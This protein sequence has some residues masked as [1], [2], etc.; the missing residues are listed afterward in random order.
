[1]NGF[2]EKHYEAP[3]KKMLVTVGNEVK[4]ADVFSTDIGLREQGHYMSV[5]GK[6]YTV[7]ENADILL[8]LQDQ[9]I[10]YFDPMVL[11]DVKIKDM[12]S[13]D[14]CRCLS[15]YIFPKMNREVETANG[16]RTDI[17][18]RFILK[19]TFDGSSSIVLYSGAIDFFCTNGLITG[20]YDVA[21]AR[22]SKNFDI[23]GFISSFNT[24]MER[25]NNLVEQYQRWADTKLTDT[26][27]VQQLFIK[28]TQPNADTPSKRSNTLADRLFAQYID[29]TQNRGNNVF[30]LQSALTHY[31]SHNDER[32]AVR[33][34]GDETTLFKREEQVRKWMSSNT[35]ND[36]LENVAA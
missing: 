25:F 23:D 31:S 15:E 33:S 8:P 12:V 14:G 3:D 27:K 26:V 9:M 11:E 32:F 19:N 28:L 18:L 6:N 34:N 5:V 17:G 20:D 1:M 30:A 21:K 2:Y 4:A 35:W 13:A 24:S 16:F 10:N 7:I 22:H 29:E 36:F